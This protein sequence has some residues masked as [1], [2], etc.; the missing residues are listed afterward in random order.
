MY[1][2]SLCSGVYSAI[3]VV[4]ANHEYDIDY[5]EAGSAQDIRL[6]VFTE[7]CESFA[8]VQ[9]E[10]DEAIPCPG[11]A[12]TFDFTP[13]PRNA[14]DVRTSIGMEQSSSRRMHLRGLQSELLRQWLARGGLR[15]RDID[16]G[17]QTQQQKT[18]M[19]RGETLPEPPEIISRISK[20]GRSKQV[21][22]AEKR[23]RQDSKA[24]GRRL[25]KAEE[26]DIRQLASRFCS[27][28][29]CFCYKQQQL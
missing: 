23:R 24:G 27:A 7:L 19:L 18:R 25:I 8:V 16:N 1:R 21:V 9:I 22:E 29:A 12:E 28:H 13:V 4:S 3:L 14:G 2:S 10:L 11:E 20:D 17:Q 6:E 15:E 5:P 26:K